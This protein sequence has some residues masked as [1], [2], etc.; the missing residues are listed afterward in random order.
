[1]NA[2][3]YV[4]AEQREKLLKTLLE[5]IEQSSNREPR[6]VKIKN[7][8]YVLSQHQEMLSMEGKFHDKPCEELLWCYL[9]LLSEF[10]FSD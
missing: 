5:E 9:R 10:G 3:N 2:C 1:M 8:N 4:Y 7:Y 6:Q